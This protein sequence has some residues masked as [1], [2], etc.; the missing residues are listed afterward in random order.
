[1]LDSERNQFYIGTVFSV[2]TVAAFFLWVEFDAAYLYGMTKEDGPLETLSAVFYGLS[3]L[4]FI[5][6]IKRSEFLKNKATG[7]RYFI[8][9]SW[10]ILMF[11]FMGEEIS[12]GQRIFN[13]STPE[14]LAEINVQNELN[15]HNIA[16]MDTFMGGK[17]RYLSVMMFTTGLFL[18][19]FVLSSIGKRTIQY[20]AFP[21]S[22]L[23]YVVLFV[24][25]Y[26]YGKYAH[27]VIGNG[28]SEVRELLMGIAMFLFALHGALSPRALF[29]V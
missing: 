11:V 22:P 14:G 21:V 26:C 19:L 5:V 8:P 1:M 17:Y 12:W 18:P 4:C 10:A 7:F 23:N 29:R 28:A 2:L 20:F 27:P 25:A 9:V 6:F 13:I 16:V 15:L 3:C 24:G